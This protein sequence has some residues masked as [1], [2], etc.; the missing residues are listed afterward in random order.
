MNVLALILKLKI[1]FPL[2]LSFQKAAMLHA[3][4]HERKR[5]SRFP[6]GHHL[7]VTDWRVFQHFLPRIYSH[8]GI[9]MYLVG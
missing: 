9:N 7:M 5:K 8:Y 3:H 2:N 4:F 1:V 6:D